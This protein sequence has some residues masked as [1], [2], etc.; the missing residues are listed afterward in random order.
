ML[1]SWA[2]SFFSAILGPLGLLL[3]LVAIIFVIVPM[4]W[5]MQYA[6]YE[7]AKQRQ[8][9]VAKRASGKKSA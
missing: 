8:G 7:Y 1:V 9:G 4:Y 5:A 2:V 6:I 3:L